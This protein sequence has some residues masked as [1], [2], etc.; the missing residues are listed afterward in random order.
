MIF[1]RRFTTRLI[2]AF[3][4][5]LLSVAMI[6]GGLVRWQTLNAE[7]VTLQRVSAGLAKHIIEHWPVVTQTD[8]SLSDQQDQSILLN[9]LMTV[10]PGIQVYLLDADG[11]VNSYI[12][13]MSMVRQYQVDLAPIQ[14]FLG[15]AAFPIR[16]TDP[17]DPSA[18][19][20]FSAAMFPPQLGQTKPPGYL[21]VA[22][23][24]AARASIASVSHQP[25]WTQTLL[26]LIALTLLCTLLIWVMVARRLGRPLDELAQKIE[27]YQNNHM[28]RRAADLRQT[29]R[30]TTEHEVARIA[31]AFDNMEQRIAQHAA[32]QQLQIETHRESIAGIAHDLRTPLTALHGYLEALNDPSTPPSNRVRL[33]EVAI[34]QSDKVRRLSKQLFELAILQSSRDLICKERFNLEELVS[35]TVQKFEYGFG[36][37]SAIALAGAAPGRI[38]IEGDMQLIERALTNLIENANQHGG[39]GTQIAV[40]IELGSADVQVLVS[41]NGPGLP[42]HLVEQLERRQTIKPTP[43]R[44]KTGGLGGLGLSIAQ[45]IAVLHG[46]NLF[47]VSRSKAGTTL[48]LVLPLVL[49]FA[50][51]SGSK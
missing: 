39:F 46:G 8:P 26:V 6:I 24:G 20:L 18:T 51:T 42:L 3:F 40:S 21:Y 14:A 44:K 10:N 47:P 11:R 4:V 27:N 19:R 9:M 32:Q 28:G 31:Q 50:V 37:R 7:S 13:D 5:V 36:N 12:G 25:V 17:M 41:D 29:K 23:D 38:E 22:L 15:S 45:R 33:L 16:G 49:P 34:Q 30:P 1:M 2:V 48:C 43:Q 35:D